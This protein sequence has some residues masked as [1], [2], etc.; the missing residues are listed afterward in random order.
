MLRIFF[1]A[2]LPPLLA[3]GI[4][5][6]TILGIVGVAG[7]RKLNWSMITWIMERFDAVFAYFVV[8]LALLALHIITRRSDWEHEVPEQMVEENPLPLEGTFI[9]TVY[10]PGQQQQYLQPQQ[11]QHQ[12]QPQQYGQY[13]QY[14]GNQQQQQQRGYGQYPGN[15]QYFVK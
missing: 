11:H 6:V 10:V 8:L 5:R 12:Q 7:P 3:R 1:Y 14:P 15:P 13:G 9:H 2:V 4:Y